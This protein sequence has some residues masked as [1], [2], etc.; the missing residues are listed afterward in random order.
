MEDVTKWATDHKMTRVA[1]TQTV[2]ADQTVAAPMPAPVAQPQMTTS[3]PAAEKFSLF[4]TVKGYL[5][6]LSAV[7][8]ST[9]GSK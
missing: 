1:T 9:L 7:G 6:K 5:A 4:D 3:V 8:R 2:A